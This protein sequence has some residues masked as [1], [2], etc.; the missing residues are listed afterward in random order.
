MDQTDRL[1]LDRARVA[2]AM[3]PGVLSC[4]PE[5]P[6][7]DVAR[8]LAMNRVH[9]VVVPQ[10]RPRGQARAWAIVSG[11]DLVRAA[12]SGALDGLTAGEVATSAP[13]AVSTE[14]TIQ[15]A[16]Q[17]MAQHEVGHL[18]VL[19]SS[20]GRPAGVLSTLDVARVLAAGAASQ[21][22]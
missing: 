2:Q 12:A 14:D 15:R 13:P 4:P 6:L 11:R 22:A 10:E 18:V 9:C 8:I 1:R 7:R 16:V 3:H 19:S 21:G 20:S 17:V 5:T